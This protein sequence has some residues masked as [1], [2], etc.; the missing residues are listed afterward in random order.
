[1]GKVG[2]GQWR[3]KEKQDGEMNLPA[4]GGLAAANPWRKWRRALTEKAA[5]LAA[6]LQKNAGAGG[7]TGFDWGE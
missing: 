4:A 2:S 6:A 7:M 5:A 3:R 1:L